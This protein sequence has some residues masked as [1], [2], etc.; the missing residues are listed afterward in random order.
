MRLGYCAMACATVAAIAAMTGCAG[1][2]NKPADTQTEETTSVTIDNS[3][4]DSSSVEA[5]I[6][7]DTVTAT[8]SPIGGVDGEDTKIR[9]VAEALPSVAQLPPER[10]ADEVR[11]AIARYI[12]DKY[13]DAR[14][15]S[16]EIL[17]TGSEQS[18]QTVGVNDYWVTY[19]IELTG[20]GRIGI[21]ETC[22]AVTEPFVHESDPLFVSAGQLYDVKNG[23]YID[24]D[25]P[26]RQS[27]EEMAYWTPE[28]LMTTNE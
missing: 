15:A 19:L 8:E 2:Q 22:S 1:N 17:G 12:V 5:D 16:A 21:M 24:T 28:R 11:I 7:E 23:T 27:D 9:I 4:G 3:Q 20:Y 18:Q 26:S 6:N 13:P 10:T 25:Q 14:I